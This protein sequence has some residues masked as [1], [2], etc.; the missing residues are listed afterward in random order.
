MYLEIVHD[1]HHLD[2][3][4]KIKPSLI[5]FVLYDK[6]PAISFVLYAIC[7]IKTPMSI[8]ASIYFFLYVE[9]ETNPTIMWK[10]CG[11]WQ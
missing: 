8:E 11:I 1:Y 9:I 3:Y 5:W 4:N 7:F 2:R 10:Y 6:G